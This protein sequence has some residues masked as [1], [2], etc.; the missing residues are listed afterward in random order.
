MPT[1]LY[2][3]ESKD[4]S[5]F[6]REHVVPETFG[7][8]NSNFVLQETLCESCNSYFG[9]TLDLKL[10]RQTIEGLDRYDAKVRKPETNTKLGG[11]P[12]LTARVKDGSFADGAEVYWARSHDGSRLVLQFFP[13]LGVMD[14]M[15]TTWFRSED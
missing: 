9:G 15:R 10:A 3:L 7:K 6:N 4:A 5:A 13:Q 1:C 12:T 11:T 8:F 14:G 2:C